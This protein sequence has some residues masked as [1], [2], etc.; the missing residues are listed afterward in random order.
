MILFS[1]LSMSM[2][3]SVVNSVMATDFM[4]SLEKDSK[5]YRNK[6][7][8]AVSLWS[9]SLQ[10]S[11]KMTLTLLKLRVGMIVLTVV[12]FI[13]PSPSSLFSFYLFKWASAYSSNLAACTGNFLK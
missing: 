7:L 10:I 13:A 6:F 4:F 9:S 2:P 8:K 12:N 11:Q 1:P 3:S 5:Y